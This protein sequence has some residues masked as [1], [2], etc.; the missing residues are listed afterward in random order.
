MVKLNGT[1]M[2]VSYDIEPADGSICLQS[3]G[4]PVLYRNLRIRDLG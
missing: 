1:K 3:E 4:W 2:N